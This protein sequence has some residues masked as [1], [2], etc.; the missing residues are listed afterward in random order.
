MIVNKDSVR[1]LSDINRILTGRI[2]G[3]LLPEDRPSFFIAY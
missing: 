1:I 2:K 3:G